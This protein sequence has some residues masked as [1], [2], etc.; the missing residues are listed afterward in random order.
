MFKRFKK[1]KNPR[2]LITGTRDNHAGTDV[3]ITY[4]DGLNDRQIV[5]FLC[6]MILKSILSL[7]TLYHLDPTAFLNDLVKDVTDNARK[8]GLD[9]NDKGDNE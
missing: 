8:L 5:S 9:E 6:D 1:N 3:R 2:V 4:D 7:I